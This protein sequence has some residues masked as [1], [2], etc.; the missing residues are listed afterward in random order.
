MEDVDFGPSDTPSASTSRAT[1]QRRSARTTA[2]SS[3][4]RRSMNEE[5]TSWRGER[6]STRLGAPPETQL[7]EPSSKRAR[8]EDSTGSAPSLNDAPVR[9]GSREPAPTKLTAS[10]AAA[11]KPTETAV[12]QLAGRKKSKFW[13]YAVEPIVPSSAHESIQNP[14]RGSETAM[15]VDTMQTNGHRNGDGKGRRGAADA[16]AKTGLHALDGSLSPALS[17]DED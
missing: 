7:D 3:S 13:F 6:R 11:V 8:T 15:E 17:M 10:G 16:R 4:N 2:G 14:I 5:W 1:G 9:N 12:E